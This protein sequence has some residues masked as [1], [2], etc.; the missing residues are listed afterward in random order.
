MDHKPL[1]GILSDRSLEEIENP[2]LENLKEKTL[3]YRFSIVHVPGVKNKVADASSRFPTNSP[4]HCDLATLQAGDK[5]TER[6]TRELVRSTRQEPSNHDIEE[7]ECVE[8]AVEATLQGSILS[9]SIG[10]SGGNCQA[11]TW[12]MIV[13]ESAKDT[14]IRQLVEVI[15]N[16]ISD[17]KINWPGNLSDYFRA[18]NDLSE[19][20]GVVSFKRRVLVPSNLQRDTL[21]VLHAAHQGCSSME[22]RAAQS[23]WWPGMKDQ[24]AKRRAACQGCTQAA[25]SQP[26]LPPVPPP[27]PDYPMQQICSDIAHY[28]GHTYVVIVDRFSNWPS[29]YKVQKAEGLVKA[30]RYHFVAHGAPEEISSDGGPEYTATETEQFLKRW[31][32]YHRLSSAYHPHS[33]LRAELGVKVVKRM[34]RENIGPHGSLDTDKMARALLAYRNTPSKDLGVSPAQI[35]YGRALRDHLPMPREF[36]QQRK[37]WILLK[38]E[39]E[40]AL[41]TKYGKLQEELERHSHPLKD[42]PV[43][44]IVQVQN[45]KGNDPLR[46]DRS[47]TVVE[48]LGNQQYSVKMDGSGRVTLRNRKFLRKIEP[49]IPRYLSLDDVLVNHQKINAKEVSIEEPTVPSSAANEEVVHGGDDEVGQRRSTRAHK[50]P[51][52]YEAKW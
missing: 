8:K 3:R 2:R 16:G 38:A 42:L 9:I 46:W 24:I 1:L 47:G 48:S 7:S 10:G 30:L 18:R 34:L 20:D 49:L 28:S 44:S 51:V 37:E 11:I 12:E 15:R 4:E 32:V 5:T 17:S 26:S 31:G 40:K 50:T 35:L 52:R 33:N 27:S 6:L 45:Q 23:I 41:S 21:D 36:L 14:E 39:R 22:A 13:R 19:K 25:P 29:V 43:G